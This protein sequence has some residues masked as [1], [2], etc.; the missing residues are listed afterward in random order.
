MHEMTKK[1]KISKCLIICSLTAFSAIAAGNALPGANP[2]VKVVKG[3]VSD[4]YINV[5]AEHTL[6]GTVRDWNGNALEGATVMPKF[7]PAHCNTDAGGHYALTVSDNDSVLCVYYPGMKAEKVRRNGEKTL[8]FVMQKDEHKSMPRTKAVATRWYNPENATTSTYCNP[9]NISYNYEPE[10]ANTKAGGA[11]RSSADPMGLTFKGE[12]YLFSTNQGGFHYSKNLSDWDFTTA[13]FQR[14]PADDDVCAPAAYVSGDTLFYTGSTYEGLPVWWSTN[15]KS[16]RFQRAMERNTLPTWDPYLFLDDD[17]QLYEY[18][19]SSNEF[20]LKGVRVSRDD[21][22]PT[23]KIVNTVMLQ[24]DRHGWERFGMNN[25][26]EFTLKPFMEGSYMTKHDGKYYL[27]YGGPGTEFKIYADGVYVGENPLGPFTYQK[28]NP[29]SYKP[30]GFVQGA[31]HGGTF[32]DVKGNYWHIATCM[33]SLKYKFER[34]IGLYPTAFDA[35]GIMWCNTAFGDYPNWNAD[36]DI[37]NPQQRFTGWMLLSYGK[38][39]EVSSCDSTFSASALTDENMRTYWA[40]ETANP[41]EWAEIDLGA[42]KTVKAIQLNYYD[43]KSIQHNRANDLYY[44]YKIY[45][46]SDGENWTLA[47]DKS[48]ND[49][50]VPHDYVELLEPLSARYLKVV[51]LHMAS[52]NFCLSEIRVFGNADGAKP[53]MVKKFSVK[54]DKKDQ[55]NAMIT[56][57][58]SAGAYG[59]NIYYGIAPDKMYNAITVNGATSYDMRGLDIGTTYY[60]TIEALGETGRSA[61]CKTIK[62]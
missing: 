35:D 11:F 5:E 38:K 8:D 41:G 1:S 37:K 59:Y 45:A 48:N 22:Y 4:Y 60:F 62:Q 46:S 21:F 25:D 17:G 49:R 44:Q 57:Q 15:P 31:G 55:R 28:H 43:Y 19:G 29:M 6:T 13:T 30:G 36:S 61:V 7:S 42:V 14:R 51:N 40:A 27:Q 3:Q 23:S 24:P 52:G 54:R 50:D 26:D 18:Y 9:L 34:R 56:W 53:A 12:Y 47:V 10:N 2:E 58:P 32:C 39:A 33:L 16:G 20:P